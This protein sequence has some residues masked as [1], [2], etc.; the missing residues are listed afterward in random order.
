MEQ[1]VAS[2]VVVFTPGVLWEEVFQWRV[3]DLVRE[4]VDLQ[5][6]EL[7]GSRGGWKFL[8]LFRNRIYNES[9]VVSMD[10]TMDNPR[11]NRP[12]CVGMGT[13]N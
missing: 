12:R 2:G 10:L 8:T 9:G 5:R 3:L 13:Y 7:A 6:C 1:I 4:K 11:R